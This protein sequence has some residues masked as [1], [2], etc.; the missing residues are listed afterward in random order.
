MRKAIEQLTDR[1]NGL[2]R[3]IA[4]GRRKIEEVEGQLT[5]DDWNKYLTVGGLRL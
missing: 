5:F 4:K 2:E 1:V 3:N